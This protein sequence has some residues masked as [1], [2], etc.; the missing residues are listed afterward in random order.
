MFYVGINRALENIF[1]PGRDHVILVD[2]F[3]SDPTNPVLTAKKLWD[4]TA[5]EDGNYMKNNAH[6]LAYILIFIP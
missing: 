5:G 4:L 3:V 2:A 1:L 6:F